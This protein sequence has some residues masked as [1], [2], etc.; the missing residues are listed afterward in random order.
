MRFSILAL[1]CAGICVGASAAWAD[2]ESSLSMP[3]SKTTLAIPDLLRDK[4][5]EEDER[6]TDL[7]L[8]ANAGSLSRYSAKFSLGY[9]G[10]PVNELEDPYKPN[11]DHRPG[12][13][14]TNLTGTMGMR[15][16]LTS[17]S[18]FNLTTGVTWF[19]P[20]QAAQ[21]HPVDRNPN[22]KTYDIANPGVS[23][24]IAYAAGPTQMISSVRA[25]AETAN[26]YVK[27]GQWG[28]FGFSQYFKYTPLMGRVILGTQLSF[29]YYTYDRDY[30]AGTTKCK[31]GDGSVSRYYFNLI[32]SFE[33]KITDVLNFNTSLGYPYQ[34]LRSSIGWLN[35][36]HPLSTWRL[37]V[38]WAITHDVY[39]NPYVNFFAESPAFNTASLNFN[40]VFSIF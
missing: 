15:Y 33:Y 3:D 14:R 19:T 2:T 38:G 11:P 31:C 25:A 22:T 37:G 35:W 10:S 23:Y 30:F 34:N 29:D 7:E 13:N 18:A 27:A 20:Y 39:V 1:A 21:N 6:I 8:R 32:P 12:D 24:D 26:Y 17:D 5:F 28:A 4:K 9:N 40:T 16:R 36:N